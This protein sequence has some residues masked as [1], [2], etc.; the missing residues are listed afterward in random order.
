[1]LIASGVSDYEV[2][3][4]FDVERVSVG[5]HRRRHL[6]KPLQDRLAILAKDSEEKRQRQELADAAASD[7]PSTL[8]LVEATLG[9]RHQIEKLAAIEARLERMSATAEQAGASAAVAQLASQQYR[10][11]ETGSRLAGLPGFTQ[12]T[13]AAGQSSS[14]RV[15]SVNIIFSNGRREEI[16]I[17][18]DHG[19]AESEADG[20]VV[21][22]AVTDIAE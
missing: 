8:A 5:R 4:L 11:I 3:R 12:P 17:L 7:M 1:M 22:T 10:G 13:Q 18:K 6:I 2:G 14:P 9:L 20:L 21:G 19:P 15:F 16:N